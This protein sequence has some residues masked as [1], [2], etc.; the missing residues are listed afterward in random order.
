MDGQL[1]GKT[2][3]ILGHESL[4]VL[5]E[6]RNRQT[7][8]D[9]SVVGIVRRPDPVPCPNCAERMGYAPNGQHERGIKQ[10]DGFM[11]ERGQ[12]SPSTR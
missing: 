10:I 9:D 2:R 5:P 3:L 11:S 4:A 7:K 8:K 1:L 6:R 12:S